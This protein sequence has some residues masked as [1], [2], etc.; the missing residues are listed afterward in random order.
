M[1]V[2]KYSVDVYL[3]C[4]IKVIGLWRMSL[5]WVNFLICGSVLFPSRYFVFENSNLLSYIQNNSKNELARLAMETIFLV[6]EEFQ[7]YKGQR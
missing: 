6:L 5:S 4:M 7:Q 2:Y 1:Y 3:L